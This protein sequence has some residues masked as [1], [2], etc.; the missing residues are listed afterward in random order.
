MW[1]AKRSGGGQVVA[2]IFNIVYID[3]FIRFL[4]FV[5]GFQPITKKIS[6]ED[7]KKQTEPK[8]NEN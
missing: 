3:V 6:V 7:Q 2:V 1:C 5:N 8:P 4:V